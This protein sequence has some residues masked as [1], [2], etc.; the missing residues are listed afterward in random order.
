MGLTQDEILTRLREND[1]EKLAELYRRAD[2]V[3]AGHVG[4]EVHLRGLIEFSNICQRSCTYCGLRRENRMLP[5]YQMSAEEIIAGA[6]EARARGYGTVVLQSGEDLNM[7]ATWLGDVVRWI[8]ERYGLAVTLSVGE[9]PVE[10]Y[11]LWRECGADRYLL[12]SETSDAELLGDLHPPRRSGLPIRPELLGI[13]RDLGYE[14]GGG[15]MVG[16]PGQSVASLARDLELFAELDLDMIGI[17][18]YIPHPGTPLGEAISAAG[19]GA[20]GE[21]PRSDDQAPNSVSMT[22]KMLSLARLACPEANIPATTALATAQDGGQLLGLK[23]GANVI[24]PNLTPRMYRERYEIYP[25]PW[26]AE[27]ADGHSAILAAISEAGRAV[28]QGPGGRRRG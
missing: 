27:G 6:G 18:P 9:R 24:M 7:S 1:P 22:L 17:G 3:R 25:S 28:G 16:L 12:K 14:I 8:K 5:R 23:C 19:G 2:A 11:R 26:R 20:A 13:L 4:E 21:A 10:D 15:V